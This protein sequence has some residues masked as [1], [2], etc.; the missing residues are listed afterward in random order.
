MV[1]RREDPQGNESGK[2]KW[3]LVEYTRGPVLDVGCGNHKPFAHFIGVDNN[4][5]AHLFGILCKPDLCM[6]AEKLDLIADQSMDE[7]YTEHTLEH[8]E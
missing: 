1:W 7:V 4:K 8:V 3:E 2:I 6:D 5:D